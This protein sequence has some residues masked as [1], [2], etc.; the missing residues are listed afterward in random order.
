MAT[1]LEILDALG[2]AK[3][4]QT[5]SGAGSVGDPFLGPVYNLLAVLGT[6]NLRTNAKL[7]TQVV[8]RSAIT[9]IDKIGVGGNITLS[10]QT[11]GSL[12]SGTT[13]YTAYVPYN[14]NGFAVGPA[15]VSSTPGG[16]NGT[17]RMTF[18][19]PSSTP[20]G[21][22]I[23]LSTD[24]GNP[25]FV[26]NIPETGAASRTSGCVITAVGTFT[27]GGTAGAVDVQVV[28]TGNQFTTAQFN[29]N[30][31][32]VVPGAITP[33]DCTGYLYAIIDITITATDFRSTVAVQPIV[34]CLDGDG[35]Y[36]AAN[37][38]PMTVLNGTGTPLKQR[39][40]AQVNGSAGVCVLLDTVSGQG[41][42][43]TASVTP[44]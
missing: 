7:G 26:C 28:G 40:L 38:I 30:N 2:A 12:V 43:M 8:Q 15:V 32:Y 4:L 33:V 19:A 42:A 29:S 25:K 11:G 16:S 22:A 39:Y 1:P 9:A 23:F 20:V 41:T 10:G 35:T 5:G 31:A 24:S 34:F 3:Y 36:Y 6:A 18:T 13:Y 21:Y 44:V 14:A 17:L 37:I 27:T